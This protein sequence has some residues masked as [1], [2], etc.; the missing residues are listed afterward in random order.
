MYIGNLTLIVSKFSGSLLV[1]PA[2][3]VNAPRI[4]ECF[5]SPE[6]R[7]LWDREI[8]EGSS[9]VLMCFEVTNICIDEAYLDEAA[10]GVTAKKDIFITC[11][12]L[13][14]RKL[15]QENPMII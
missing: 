14:I 4:K 8:V 3:T 10:Q 5:L 12:I 2:S 11:I 15:L 9:H 1:E 7:Y 13:S 6:S